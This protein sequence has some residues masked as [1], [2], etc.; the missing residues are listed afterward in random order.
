M[1]KTFFPRRILHWLGPLA[2]AGLAA[3]LV[4]A[5]VIYSGV[6]N[7]AATTPHPQYLTHILHFTFRR[8]LQSQADETPP[9]DLAS[10]ARMAIGATHY[11]QVCANCHGAPGIG[12]S[13][14]S[15]AMTPRPPWLPA[16]IKE[17]TDAQTFW[18]LKHGVKY[19][20]MPGWPTQTRD[21]EI[22]NMV[23]F[24]RALPGMDYPAYRRLAFGDAPATQLPPMPFGD[25]GPGRAY[26]SYNSA[27]PQG[28]VNRY[29]WPVS[30]PNEAAQLNEPLANCARCHGAGGNGR[31]VG[32]FPNLT[33]QPHAYLV[34][35]LQNFASGARH[36]A[37]M[38]TV[39]TQLSPAQMD[40]VAEYYTAAA[41][42]RAASFGTA[43]AALLAQGATIAN[44]L[45]GG[46]AQQGCNWCHNLKREGEQVFPRLQGQD[47]RYLV[48]QLRLFRGGGRIDPGVYNPM[49]KIA[50][51]LTDPQMEAVAAYYAAQAP[52][53]RAPQ[54]LGS[55]GY[56]GPQVDPA[57][58][59]A[60]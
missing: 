50:K 20:A 33:I 18:V 46:G 48:A 14:V 4:A 38:Q 59:R 5:T 34:R 41:P 13:P 22:W 8:V 37:V 26:A 19:S 47:A 27:I 31:A 11:A 7:L 21:D 25:A 43:S 29:T 51:T 6:Y 15:L 32:G 17:L 45:G 55:R 36:S 52:T 12:Q 10:P 23:S 1:L 44:G 35:Q 49:T 16:Q 30:G 54:A 42:V 57:L 24:V 39:A 28:N 58:V 2:A 56:A 40:G 9:A 60:R 3:L 53:A